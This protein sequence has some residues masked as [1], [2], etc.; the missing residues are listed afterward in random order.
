M[1]WEKDGMKETERD[2]QTDGE[3]V[4][5]TERKRET[6]IFILKFPQKRKSDS[7]YMGILGGSACTHR[8]CCCPTM[9]TCACR[10]SDR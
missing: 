1:E 3:A 2:K 8:T 5:Q 6:E 4:R 10:Y 9:R 7:H